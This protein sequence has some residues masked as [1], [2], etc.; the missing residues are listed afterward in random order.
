MSE[1]RI[2]ITDNKDHPSKTPGVTGMCGPKEIGDWGGGK[3]EYS[4]PIMNY[5]DPE[6][7]TGDLKKMGI[8]GC[9]R[10]IAETLDAEISDS[11][12]KSAGLRKLLEAQDCMMR[13]SEK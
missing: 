3:K 11:A 10:H 2:D 8:A 7:F 12:E 5:F 4:N 1:R 13:A 6:R 9:F